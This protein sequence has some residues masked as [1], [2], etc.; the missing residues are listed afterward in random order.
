MPDPVGVV[1]VG[2]VQLV[3]AGTGWRVSA[4]IIRPQSAPVQLWYETD[5]A[6]VGGAEHLV[7]PFAIAGVL[8]AMKTGSDFVMRQSL[9]KAF[10]RNLEEFIDIWATLQPALFR[11][12]RCSVE[13]ASLNRG[14]A[15]SD[16]GR[17]EDSAI[18]CFSGGV[19][20]CHSLWM[21]C[22]RQKGHRSLSVGAGML[23]DGFDIGLDE[24]ERFREAEEHCRAILD[25]I[26]VRLRTVRTN[27]REVVPHWRYTHGAALVS[28]LWLFKG[29]FSNGIV[30]TDD[31]SYL[32]PDHGSNPYT[33]PLLSGSSFRIV[34]DGGRY[35]RVEKVDSIKEWTS[36]L[37]HLRV[38]YSG[39]TGGNCGRCE[40][41]IR[42]VLNFRTVGMD[43]LACFPVNITNDDI[44]ALKITDELR[45][46]HLRT[47][48]R[49]AEA[50]G[51]GD[52]P[53]VRALD[54]RVRRGCNRAPGKIGRG[55]RRLVRA[56][57]PAAR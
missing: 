56:V 10:V 20:A 1:T 35:S 32:V 19:D 7:E 15:V 39:N 9:E 26:G 48:L 27:W 37:D 29:A 55:I 8:L 31:R 42:T 23:V 49:E 45:M 38:C 50:R 17:A 51:R 12:V 16:S 47:I 57:L 13:I 30:G 3:Q 4:D 43:S 33:C 21:H 2:D 24:K 18:V 44:A 52:E 54:R 22:S 36:A 6:E 25:S 53:W 41:C 46:N 28:C 5:A 14:E 34:S 40:K 11:P